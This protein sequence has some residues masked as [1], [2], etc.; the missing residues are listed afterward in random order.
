MNKLLMVAS[1]ISPRWGSEGAVG[2]NWLVNVPDNYS[3]TLLTSK[4]C[5]S[6][7]RWGIAN[8]QAAPTLSRIE[9]PASSWT[10]APGSRFVARINEWAKF[11]FN[12]R[13]M[14]S[15]ASHMKR[16]GEL[17]V[18]HQTTIASWM[19][20]MPFT[21][22]GIP[23]VWGPLGGGEPFPWRYANQTSFLSC[24][25]E[26]GRSLATAAARISRRVLHDVREVDVIIVTNRQTEEL[27]RSLGRTKP[28]V[29]QP[30]VIRRSRYE[31]VRRAAESKRK[32]PIKMI[33]SGSVEGRKGL[34][35]T[36]RALSKLK[37]LGVPIDF[38]VTGNG[39]ELSKLRNLVTECG[40][41]G[42]VH[43]ET[44]LDSDAYLH[45]LAESHIFCFPSLRDNS[46]VALLEAMAAACVPIVLDNGGP[47]ETVDETCGFVLPLESPEKT[48]ER[49][50][51]NIRHLMENAPLR[52]RLARTAQ[53]KVADCFLD[54][55]LASVMDHAYRAAQ[56][57][58]SRHNDD[59]NL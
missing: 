56:A 34:S 32:A 12:L 30:M 8:G 6:E 39:M 16:K 41:G 15:C 49:M 38:T 45:R 10:Y 21:S 3:T 14:H 17:D 46:P 5:A 40:L 51:R 55:N 7:V 48:I 44:N 43:F 47:S 58:V 31:T 24:A 59:R 25:F 35:L 22:M 50:A 53:A 2:W 20:G 4:E 28:I 33:S 23:T 52:M 9:E 11:R 37:H 27:L 57:R 54:D 36:I 42:C 26:A 19:G 18:V 13:A 1:T 29:K